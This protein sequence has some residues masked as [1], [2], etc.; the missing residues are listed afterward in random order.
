[1]PFGPD[2]GTIAPWPVVASLPF[3]PDIVLPT[4]DD[5][6]HQ[7]KLKSFNPCGFKATLN[8]TYSVKAANRNAWVLPWHYG[9]NQGPV[10][11]KIENYRT[12]LLWQLTGRCSYVVT[13]LRRAGCPA[14]G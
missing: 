12:E 14:V 9:L 2:D 3:A 5:F 1:M 10:V 13:G 4:I 8:A 7:L 11:L 6:I